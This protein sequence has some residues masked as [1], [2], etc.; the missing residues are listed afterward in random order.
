[1]NKKILAI[2]RIA[3][4]KPTTTEDRVDKLTVNGAP[5]SSAVALRAEV[6]KFYTPETQWF[7]FSHR[8]QVDP[9][10]TDFITR[11]WPTPSIRPAS[12]LAY[13]N[14]VFIDYCTSFHPKLVE[15]SKLYTKPLADPDLGVFI[16]QQLTNL[17]TFSGIP[18]KG[19]TTYARYLTSC[20]RLS[21]M[22]KIDLKR[23]EGKGW[24]AFAAE[25]IPQYGFFGLN[26][27]EIQKLAPVVTSSVYRRELTTSI[28]LEDKYETDSMRTGNH[29]RFLAHAKLAN[30]NVNEICW[31][32]IAGV[33]HQVFVAIKPI[34]PDE[35]DTKCECTT[36]YGKNPAWLLGK[37]SAD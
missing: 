15:L 28:P 12:N 5:F 36:T 19:I 6:N 30:I 17:C 14:S 24:C 1:M 26:S 34:D 20:I 27:G 13:A 9:A 37:T 23:V 33:P 11:T 16:Q 3:A 18:S 21:V 8:C 29:M 10:A 35:G 32:R 4:P 25:F 7:A 22:P 2:S 31:V